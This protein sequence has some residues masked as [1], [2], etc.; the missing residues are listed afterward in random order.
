MNE[1]RE[2]QSSRREFLKS[3]TALAITPLLTRGV[4]TGGTELLRV[5]LIGCGGRGSGACVQALRADENARLV[6]MADAFPD[7][8]EQSLARLRKTSVAGRV[9][10]NPEHRFTGLDG[11]KGVI[12][13]SDVVLLASP[14]HFR[15]RHLEAA[16][17]AGKHVFCEKPVAVDAPGLRAVLGTCAKAREKGLSLV[18]GLCWR[19]DHGMQA[20]FRK[21]HEGAIGEIVAIQATYHS[22]GLWHRGRRPEWSDMEWQI[23]NWTYFTW[24]AGDIIVEQHIHSLDKVAWAMQDVY[25]VRAYGNGGRQTRTDPRFGNVWDHFAI[26]YEFE[27]GVKAFC[28]C[29][30]NDGCDSNVSDH[31]MGTKGVC[32]VFRHRTIGETAWRYEGPKENMYQNEHDEL[33]ASIRSGKPIHNGDYMCK[34]TLMAIMGRMAGYTG[35]VVTWDQVMSSK[36]DLTPP[37]YDFGP[38]AT[39]PVAKPGLTKFV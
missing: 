29:R 22:G 3:S 27:G 10:V 7:R 28:S 9:Q 26:C 23:R 17:G 20:T 38:I 12:E 34:S 18:S 2:P 31:V 14:P 25:P 1:R 36:E 24:L 11:Y 21:I 4:H 19:Y 32:D 16:I 30:Q 37:S 33:F 5:G 6:A 8:L 35:K 13:S 39:P 15:P